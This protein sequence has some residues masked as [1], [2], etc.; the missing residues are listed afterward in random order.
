MSPIDDDDRP[1]VAR[2]GRRSS[3][4]AR[5]EAEA[6]WTA[7]TPV[8]R[9]RRGQGDGGTMVHRQETEMDSVGWL[10]CRRGLR[11]GQLYQLKKV[12]NEM[13]RASECEVTIEDDFA[14]AHHGAV[15]VE[16]GAWKVFDFASTNGTFINGKRLGV[17]TANPLEL[18]DG[19]VVSIGDTELVFKRI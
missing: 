2:S 10:Y 6:R 17:D 15:V 16:T 11:K 5:P 14:S 4:P 1:T 3:P 7:A 12:R 13:G 9:R 19:D 18:N 8:T